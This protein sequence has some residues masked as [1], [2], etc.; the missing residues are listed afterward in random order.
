[1]NKEE[2]QEALT[3]WGGQRGPVKSIEARR[4]WNQLSEAVVDDPIGFMDEMVEVG[5]VEWKGAGHYRV[6][7]HGHH[8]TLEGAGVNSRSIGPALVI[9]WTCTSCGQ[10]RTTRI[11]LEVPHE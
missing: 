5:L 11:D 1:M 6:I 10:G 8:W 4:V 3:R 2:Q 9:D 7:P